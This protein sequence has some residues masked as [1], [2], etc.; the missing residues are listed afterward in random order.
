[1]TCMKDKNTQGVLYIVA[2][3]IGNVDDI[4]LRAIKILGEAELIVCEDTRYAKKLLGG[5]GIRARLT[6]YFDAKER[7]RSP[8]L[9]KRL[10]QGENL[11]LISDA[12]TPLIS[13]PGYH[14]VRAVQEAGI[15]VIPIPGPSALTAALSICGLPTDRFIFEGFLPNKTS[16]R[17]RKLT[18]LKNETGTLLFFEA[19]H[20]LAAMLA[21][22]AEVFG[23]DRAVVIARE[24][25]KKFETLYRGSAA[26]LAARSCEE[27]DM[28]RG[29]LVVIVSGASA[30][31]TQ[32]HFDLDRLLHSLGRE[33]GAAR[34]SKVAA[35]ITGQ[36]KSTLYRQMLQLQRSD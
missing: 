14:L 28:R 11:A 23:A 25:T 3:P 26:S 33:L 1:M 36:S 8:Q 32:T 24:L 17:Q 20:R 19:P 21:D 5:L 9:V 31:A 4:S 6:S 2:T 22:L 30:T 18:K 34:G 15:R 16:A 7:E 10:R 29:E 13:D 35:E 27:A 12:G